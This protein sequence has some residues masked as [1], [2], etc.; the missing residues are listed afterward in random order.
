M[1]KCL[2]LTKTLKITNI[3]TIT[4]ISHV[5]L[6][7]EC[8]QTFCQFWAIFIPLPHFYRKK[9]KFSKNEIKKKRLQ[10]L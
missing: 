4:I 6:Q 5:V 2:K 10:I 3:L 7:I 8:G 1:K 9:S